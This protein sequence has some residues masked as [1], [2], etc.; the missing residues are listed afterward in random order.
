[1]I[2]VNRL[3]FLARY[4]GPGSI[5]DGIPQEN[6]FWIRSV[7]KYLSVNVLPEDL[8]IEAGLAQIRKILA[9]KEYDANQNGKFAVFNA[10]RIIQYMSEYEGMDVQIKHRPSHNDPTHAGIAP[11]GTYNANAWYESTRTMARALT[12]FFEENP[13][14]V[15]PVP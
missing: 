9:R 14:S 8:G 7:E 11:A 5:R 12:K 6:A 15:Y 4:C 3:G 1:M 2:D 10:G 13:D